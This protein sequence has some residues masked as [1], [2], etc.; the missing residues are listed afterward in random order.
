MNKKTIF[1]LEEILSI[2]PH[3]PPFLFVD[4]V[5]KFKPNSIIVAQRKIH[6][7]EPWFQGHF[8]QKAI[9]PG[10]LVLDAL[11]QT[12][13]LLLGF[14]KKSSSETDNEPPK[15]YYLASSNIKFTSPAF[16]GETLELIAENREKFE[17]LYSYHVEAAVG[18]KTVA[19][20][21]L[22]LAAIEGTL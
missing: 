4:R 17:N 11:A 2:I 21:T 6:P 19:K 10:A 20:G 14:S 13:G 15:L 8:P 9:M 12:S 18:R 7:D 3:R 16:P 22:T 5:I 1:G